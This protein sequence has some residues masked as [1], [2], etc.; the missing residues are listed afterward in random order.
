MDIVAL[1]K[2]LQV[3]TATI[4][5]ALRP[6][7]AH[8]VREPLRLRIQKAAQE[9]DYTPSA[10]ARGMRAKKALIVSIVIPYEEYIFL[11]EYHARLVF[12]IMM[13]TK[14]LGL[15]VRM[16]SVDNLRKDF[17]E[18]MRSVSF[19]SGGV[20]YLGSTLSDDN[21]LQLKS[22]QRPTVVIKSSLPPNHTA[23]E[24]PATV[25]GVDNVHGG[26]LAAEHLLRRGHRRIGYANAPRNLHYD[27]YERLMGIRKAL[28]KFNVPY[29]PDLYIE[30]NP[31]F[32]S[33]MR[34]WKEFYRSRR[35]TAIICMNDELA[36]GLIR[37][38]ATDGVRCPEDLAVVGYDD[39]R[40]A[41]FMSPGLTSVRQSLDEVGTACVTAIHAMLTSERRPAEAKRDID[42][43]PTLVIRESSGGPVAGNPA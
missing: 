1:A 24:V 2:K 23:A 8:L 37:E 42:F 30:C 32:G 5:R 15:D 21:M 13:T 11:G 25:V 10:A 41:Y 35:P 38:A 22:L 17:V 43:K 14:K 34:I 20:I 18:R 3:S 31:D 33:G 16:C 19:G 39:S 4:S 27:A 6:E 9:L 26:F 29:D 12:S 28:A 36:R 40:L 7:V